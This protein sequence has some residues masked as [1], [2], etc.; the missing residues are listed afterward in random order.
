M[1]DSLESSHPISVDVKNPDEIK[2]I[3]DS[4]SYDKGSSIIRMMNSYLSEKTFRAGVSVCRR[5]RIRL[6]YK[7]SFFSLFL[8][9]LFK[10]I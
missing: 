2:S 5:L 9:E 3:F 1:K 4:I 10:T 7:Q 6:N 8:I